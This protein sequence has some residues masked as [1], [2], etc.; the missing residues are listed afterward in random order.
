MPQGQEG[1]VQT[2]TSGSR[3]QQVMVSWLK[4][5]VGKPYKVGP[6][7]DGSGG[8]FDCSGLVM[9]AYKQIG[10]TGFGSVSYTQNQ[11]GARVNVG[12]LQP[13]DLIFTNP[14]K[15]GAGPGQPGHVKIYIGNGKVIQ[16]AST[17]LGVIESPLNTSDIM[18]V[19]RIIDA[20]GKPIASESGKIAQGSAD[21]SGALANDEGGDVGALVEPE[22]AGNGASLY[23]N[24]DLVKRPTTD[25]EINQYIKDNYGYMVGFLNDP[26][27]GPILRQAAQEGLSKD[28]LYGRLSGTKWWKTYSDNQRKWQQIVNE[29]P[30]TA[31]AQRASKKA[32]L[33]NQV[34]QLGLVMSAQDLDKIV[35]Q[36]LAGGLTPDEEM[37]LLLNFAKPSDQGFTQGDLG[38]TQIQIQ[39]LQ[40]QYMLVRGKGFKEVAEIAKRVLSGET[41]LDA[42][43]ANFANQAKSL[44]ANN[45]EMLDL[46]NKGVSPFDATSN[47]RNAMAN[48]LEID[49]S[50]V[51][52]VNNQ[53]Y[54][55]ALDYVDPKS[56]KHRLMTISEAENLARSQPGWKNTTNARQNWSN[57]VASIGQYAG[58]A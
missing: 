23:A 31:A 10:I 12:S 58:V 43:R 46:L 30:A 42:V 15:N 28:M 5:Q 9:G 36:S 52:M 3:W 49:P 21:G 1:G 37:D 25:A 35:E 41:T 45:E 48:L 54:R 8:Y 33:I 26:E 20:T 24:P 11:Y 40:D 57:A 44:F 14:G 47:M 39:Q 56:G 13:G 22:S 27:L 32:T 17:K 50:Q 55:Q 18:E 38:A 34:G 51:D 29:D 2:Q 7:R 19:R 6:G 53:Q 4:A 16:A